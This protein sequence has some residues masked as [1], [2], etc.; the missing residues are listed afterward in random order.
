MIHDRYLLDLLGVSE[1]DLVYASDAFES[2]RVEYGLDTVKFIVM[3]GFTSPGH[4]TLEWE[5]GV[6][7]ITGCSCIMHTEEF[8]RTWFAAL[9]LR[10]QEF[11]RNGLEASARG[12]T[13]NE[14]FHKAYVLNYLPE[15]KLS[16][17]R[18]LL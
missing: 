10:I 1:G 7:T 14:F 15:M 12:V 3:S 6:W 8:F 5:D 4:M 17:W 18:K 2:F 16:D 9:A 13:F 11:E